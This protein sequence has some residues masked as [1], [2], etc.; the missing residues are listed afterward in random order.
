MNS[1]HFE[2]T[3]FSADINMCTF[4]NNC[5]SMSRPP[6][7]TELLCLKQT[8]GETKQFGESFLASSQFSRVL[9]K[10][11]LIGIKK[12]TTNKPGSKPM[13]PFLLPEKHFFK[14]L[15]LN[16]FIQAREAGPGWSSLF[17]LEPVMF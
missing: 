6:S 1:L 5:V 17:T 7:G 12:T 4:Y 10:L 13:F 2:A 16:Q 8:G 3:R 14:P 9:Q 15:A 11:M